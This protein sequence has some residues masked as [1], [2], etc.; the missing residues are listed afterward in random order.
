M[1]Y[2]LYS[3]VYRTDVNPKKLPQIST[4]LDAVKN[5]QFEMQF[6]GLGV[7]GADLTLAAKQVQGINVTMSDIEVRRLNDTVYYPGKVTYGALVVTFDNLTLKKTAP[8]LWRWFTN[9]FDPITGE[10]MKNGSNFLKKQKATLLEL[11]N[12]NDIFSTIDFFGIYPSQIKWSDKAYSG[13]VQFSTVEV[14][15]RYDYL[16]Y[17]ASSGDR[18]GGITQALGALGNP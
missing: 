2:S 7:N 6:P 14:T 1:A 12:T 17:T 10:V 8:E 15:F 11:T 9:T 5:N 16:N 18:L 3:T 13:D 4:H